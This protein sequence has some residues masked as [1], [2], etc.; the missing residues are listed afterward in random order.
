MRRLL[1][2]LGQLPKERV[3]LVVRATIGVIA[4]EEHRVALGADLRLQHALRGDTA[5]AK[6]HYYAVH[7][8]L[9]KYDGEI[10]SMWGEY[11]DDL[12]RTPAGWRVKNRL[13]RSIMTEGPVVTYKD[14]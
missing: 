6:V 7:K 2:V 5:K 12:V 8:G 10:Y 13:Y 14:D 9:N 4:D 1:L 3:E 11:V